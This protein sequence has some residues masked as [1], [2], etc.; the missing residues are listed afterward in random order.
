[1]PYI[2]SALNDNSNYNLEAQLATG[3]VAVTVLSIKSTGSM[4]AEVLVNPNGTRSIGNGLARM[5]FI[6]NAPTG[7]TGTFRVTQSGL[8]LC[9][10]VIG[11][12]APVDL[13]V[14]FEVV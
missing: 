10:L 14:A 9:D 8:T 3:S 4:S 1:M 11:N 12:T 5:I 2:T 13:T 6:V 7:T